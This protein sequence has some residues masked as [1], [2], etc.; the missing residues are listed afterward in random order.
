MDFWIA[1]EQIQ[2][3]FHKENLRLMEE[4]LLASIPEGA[5]ADGK[6]GDW[7]NTSIRHQRQRPTRAT[8]MSSNM[9]NSKPEKSYSKKSVPAFFGILN[10]NIKSAHFNTLVIESFTQIDKV[11]WYFSKLKPQSDWWPVLAYPKSCGNCGISRIPYNGS[12]VSIIENHPHQMFWE[13]LFTYLSIIRHIQSWY[14]TI[15]KMG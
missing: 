14:E 5:R 3:K 7:T 11:S 15:V 8:T 6:T 9:G 12:Y 1:V 10:F 13:S 2:L 4:G